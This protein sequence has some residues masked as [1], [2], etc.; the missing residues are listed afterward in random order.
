[1]GSTNINLIQELSLAAN[2]S[3]GQFSFLLNGKAVNP[4]INSL[5]YKAGT[6]Q[7]LISYKINLCNIQDT[8]TIIFIQTPIIKISND[9]I[10]CDRQGIFRLQT[11]QKG[12]IWI[13]PAVNPTTGLI[14]LLA[15]STDTVSYTYVYGSGTSCESHQQ[16]TIIIDDKG[17]GVSAGKNMETDLR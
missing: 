11:N 14:D 2:P 1:M 6:Y 8:A 16:C 3:G 5:N 7:L 10:L 9:T 17:F 12:G 15:L 13:G 4:I